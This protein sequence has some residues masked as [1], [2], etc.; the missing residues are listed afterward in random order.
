MTWTCWT[1]EGWAMTVG[2]PSRDTCSGFPS[3][4]PD[5]L[6]FFQPIPIVSLNVGFE[7]NGLSK[8]EGP[9]NSP[10]RLFLKAS[11]RIRSPG[12]YS[13]L[14]RLS[15]SPVIIFLPRISTTAF[16]NPPFKAPFQRLEKLN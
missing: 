13:F 16:A 15:N 2:V 3:D 6:Y 5:G 14:L 11:A 8:N 7:P 12:V 1:P 9:S 10:G 4:D